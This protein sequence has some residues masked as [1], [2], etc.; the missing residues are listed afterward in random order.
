MRAQAEEELDLATRALSLSREVRDRLMQYE[1]AAQTSP[2]KR[3][4]LESGLT[5]SLSELGRLL[6]QTDE[7][8]GHLEKAVRR[9]TD[10]IRMGGGRAG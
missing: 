7:I 4:E 8:V 10:F 6:V 3:V 5:M 9:M 1:A 2:M